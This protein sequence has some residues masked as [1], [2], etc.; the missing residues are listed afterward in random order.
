[1]RQLSAI[2]LAL[3]V[4]APAF[5]QVHSV[6]LSGP[7]PFG[8]LIGDV[9]RHDIA[10]SADPGFQVVPA[11]LPRAG[12]LTYWLDLRSAELEDLGVKSGA[13]R[14]RLRLDYQ[15]FYAPLQPQALEIPSFSLTLVKGDR[16]AAAVVPAWTFLMSPLREIM[17]QSVDGS[18]YLR[19]DLLPRPIDLS[20]PRRVT[21]ASA[22]ATV[23]LL[24]LLAYHRA[25]WPFRSR[26]SRPFAQALRALRG[27]RQGSGDE[28]AYRAALLAF[29]RAF[30]RTAGRRVLAE[31][32]PD[33]LNAAPAFRAAGPDLQRF[34]LASR[35]A[36]FGS[37]T[38][39]AMELL[40]SAALLELG[41]RLTVAERAKA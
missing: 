20:V 11:S 34:F 37:D 17:P 40:P 2:V 8:F 13:Q 31:D 24:A 9:L 5:A 23:L 7:R 30:D 18:V 32:L 12:P 38:A 4:A 14:F 6:E 29:H 1:M 33:F 16:R 3:L 39:G 27:A 26:S 35:R 21:I 36:F 10:I 28:A 22:A 25:W 15:T 19:P 41:K